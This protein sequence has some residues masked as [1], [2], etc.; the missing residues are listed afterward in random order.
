MAARFD[1]SDQLFD[2]ICEKESYSEKE[3]ANTLKPVVDAL[4]YC[5]SQGIAHRDIKVAPADTA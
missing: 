3:A 1:P 4:A 2:R 5:H